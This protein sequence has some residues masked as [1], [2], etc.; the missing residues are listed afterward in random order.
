MSTCAGVGIRGQPLESRAESTGGVNQVQEGEADDKPG[1]LIK[2][3][4]NLNAP[5]LDPK[6]ALIASSNGCTSDAGGEFRAAA[7][8]NAAILPAFPTWHISNRSTHPIRSL[9]CYRPR[10]CFKLVFSSASRVFGRIV[11]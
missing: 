10:H 8:D 2:S 5:P 7:A 11:P 1:Q 3:P 9:R 6:S 4:V